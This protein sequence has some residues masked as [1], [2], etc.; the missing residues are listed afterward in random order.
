MGGE[1]GRFGRSA[2]MRSGIFIIFQMRVNTILKKL[3]HS[4]PLL[5]VLI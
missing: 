3:D 1:K 5:L 2:W 4:T